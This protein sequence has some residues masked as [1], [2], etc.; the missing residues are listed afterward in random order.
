M[1]KGHKLYFNKGT[2][3]ELEHE[4]TQKLTCE[5]EAVMVC[6]RIFSSKRDAAHAAQGLRNAGYLVEIIEDKDGHALYR[7]KYKFG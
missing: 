1:A 4:M 2:V 7:S 5:V 3:T 6:N